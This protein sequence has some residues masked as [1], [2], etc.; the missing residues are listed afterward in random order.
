MSVADTEYVDLDSAI[1]AIRDDANAALEIPGVGVDIAD[2]NE[3]ELYVVADR[4]VAG[5]LELVGT[6]LVAIAE[7][8]DSAIVVGEAPAIDDRDLES[9]GVSPIFTHPDLAV[10]TAGQFTSSQSTL[11]L[12]LASMG[13]IP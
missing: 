3:G 2:D 7:L 8:D 13:P 1:V 10:I 4:I 5:S 12:P 9:V 11:R 6:L